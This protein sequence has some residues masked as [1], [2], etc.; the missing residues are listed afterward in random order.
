M[1]LLSEGKFQSALNFSRFSFYRI[2]TQ[3][4]RLTNSLV[5][6]RQLESGLYEFQQALGHDRGTLKGLEGALDKGQTTPVELAQNVKVVA[7]LLS[8]RVNVSEEQV[9]IC[10]CYIY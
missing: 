7:K 4:E 3:L 1:S 2:N 10:S 6:W 5:A 8:E 9:N